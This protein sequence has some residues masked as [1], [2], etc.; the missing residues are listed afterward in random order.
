MLDSDLILG[1]GGGGLKLEGGIPVPPLPLYATLHPESTQLEHGEYLDDEVALSV[2][3]DGPLLEDSHDPPIL[4]HSL[5]VLLSLDQDPP[6]LLTAHI[7]QL[8]PNTTVS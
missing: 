1:G 2:G 3:I 7:A 4:F 5:H 8:Q 6:I